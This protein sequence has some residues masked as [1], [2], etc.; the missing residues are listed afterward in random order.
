MSTF[1]SACIYRSV[2]AYDT[3]AFLCPAKVPKRRVVVRVEKRA[4]SIICPGWPHREAIE[5]VNIVPTVDFITGLCSN[6]F[7][8]IVKDPEHRLN[9][10]IPFSGPSRYALRCNRCFIVPKCQ[11]D[12]FSE[13]LDLVLI[14][15]IYV[16]F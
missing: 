11:T 2:L 10:L 13:L 14:I 3:P 8:T 1:Y 12:R 5:L 7:D 6:T 4:M 16:D 9:S 15:Y